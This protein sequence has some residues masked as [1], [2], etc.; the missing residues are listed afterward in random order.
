MDPIKGHIDEVESIRMMRY[1]FDHGV[2]Y[3]D[4]AYGY[5]GGKSEIVVGKALQDGYRKKVRVATKMPLHD[6]EK[7]EDFDRIFNEQ[8][9][10]LQTDY[11]DFYLCHGVNGKIWP[12]MRD[13]GIVDWGEKMKDEGKIRNFGF[14]FHD[15][16]PILREVLGSYP[17]WDF[18]Q[19]QYNY[20][21]TGSSPRS[22]GTQGLKYAA[23]KGLPVVVMEPIR[24]GQLAV[25][26]PA[27][28]Q[29]IW[30][31]STVKRS[32]AEWALQWVWNHPEVSVVLSGMSTMQQVVENVQSAERSG[33]GPLS[34]E[35]L[36]IIDR[37]KQ[38][39]AKTGYIGCTGCQ[40]CQPCPQGVAIPEIIKVLNRNYLTGHEETAK[41][42]IDSVAPENRADHCVQCG[43]CEGKCPQGL[44]IMTLMRNADLAV[45]ILEMG[46]ARDR[47]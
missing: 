21:D 42:Y 17:G 12:K 7:R 39:Y 14:S 47:K 24:G 10:K 27:Q 32:P 11:V 20:L 2:N 45:R 28:I 23:S 46:R 40:Y 6:V 1:A 3:V 13:L 26:P 16:F 33:A 19:I 22:P 44:A 31:E 38:A 37:V 4:S 25:K 34:R 18:L 41:E 8:L 29:E 5:G 35:E 36:G 43:T 9:A 30:D 15:E